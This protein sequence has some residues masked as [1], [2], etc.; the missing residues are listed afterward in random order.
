MINADAWPN[1]KWLRLKNWSVLNR[2]ANGFDVLQKLAFIS[3]FLHIYTAICVCAIVIVGL[4]AGSL[5]IN[6]VTIR[7]KHILEIPPVN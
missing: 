7:G 2:T 6:Y 4:I 3:C 1:P 5:L